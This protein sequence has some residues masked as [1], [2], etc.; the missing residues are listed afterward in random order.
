MGIA[1]GV[2]RTLTLTLLMNP[3]LTLAALPMLAFASA[4][5][6][7]SSSSSPL[8]FQFHTS[9][10]VAFNAAV[11]LDFAPLP[12]CSIQVRAGLEGDTVYSGATNEQ[13]QISVELKWPAEI[14]QAVVIAQYARSF[15]EHTGLE[16]GESKSPF[17]PSARL[18]VPVEELAQITVHLMSEDR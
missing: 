17:A 3:T 11:T 7:S 1:F 5:S 4:C 13:G 12:F 6:P 8:P 16:T 14:E 9:N 2:R 10:Q 18:V 15:G